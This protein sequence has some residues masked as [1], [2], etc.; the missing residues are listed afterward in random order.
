MTSE[1]EVEGTSAIPRNKHA[2]E[3]FL[4]NE[5]RSDCGTLE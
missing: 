2:A 4:I 1:V 3:N 5:K